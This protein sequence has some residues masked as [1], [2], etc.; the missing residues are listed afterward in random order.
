MAAERCIEGA[1]SSCVLVHGAANAGQAFPFGEVQQM[2]GCS[3]VVLSMTKERVS[4]L[5]L[6]SLIALLC[7]TP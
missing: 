3:G 6:C 5:R 1:M 2:N 4:N 7:S